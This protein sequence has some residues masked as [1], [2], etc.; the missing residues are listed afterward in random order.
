[1]FLIL[2]RIPEVDKFCMSV[3]HLH[4]VEIQKLLKKERC[5][6]KRYILKKLIKIEF[7]E[8]NFMEKTNQN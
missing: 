8:Y 5:L 7:D 6:W 2:L 4:V 1:M 3:E